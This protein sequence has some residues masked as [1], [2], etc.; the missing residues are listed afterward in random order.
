MQAIMS[1]IVFFIEL[2]I[3]DG[4]R[5]GQFFFLTNVIIG[6]GICKLV[7]MSLNPFRSNI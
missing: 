5:D 6:L 7:S 3:S 1:C 2:F 4:R